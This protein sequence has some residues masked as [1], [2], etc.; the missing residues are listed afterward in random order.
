MT[1]KTGDVQPSTGEKKLPDIIKAIFGSNVNVNDADN[2]HRTPLHLAV[3][4]NR[5]E[6]AEALIA[7][8]A[9]LMVTLLCL[10]ICMM[11]MNDR[12]CFF[13]ATTK[14]NENVLHF[15]LM[16]NSA[17]SKE[18]HKMVEFILPKDKR[19]QKK[20][21]GRTL[22]DM[23]T[24]DNQTPLAYALCHPAATEG[25]IKRLLNEIQEMDEKQLFIAFAMMARSRVYL[26][27]PFTHLSPLVD[28]IKQRHYSEE[29]LH[30]LSHIICQKNNFP[31]LNWFHKRMMQ[32]RLLFEIRLHFSIE[33][34]RVNRFLSSNGGFFIHIHGYLQ[35]IR[36]DL[37]SIFY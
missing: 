35:K 17:T 24:L 28:W 32:V 9:N 30:Q 33:R 15:A 11:N 1:T 18:L 10:T 16:S 34:H 4:A 23:P 12:T 14:F 22:I 13:Q 25:L 29:I 27:E 19:H 8:E 5:L 31:L 2:D 21:E 20:K 6:F 36:R 37:D 7:R 26:N 3:Q